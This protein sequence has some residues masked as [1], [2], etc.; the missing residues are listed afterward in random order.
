MKQLWAAVGLL[1]LL[2]AISLSNAWFV[3]SLTSRMTSQ[4]EQAHQLARDE[5]WDEATTITNQTYQDWQN[6]HF[7]LHSALRHSDTDKILLGFRCT[8]QYLDLE[9]LDQYA[10]ANTDLMT[11]LEL[12][13]EMEQPSLVNIL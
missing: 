3:N 9:E 2:L 5:Q 8:L 1:T 13:A 7:Y 12:L 4:L 10:A 11:Q 6:H